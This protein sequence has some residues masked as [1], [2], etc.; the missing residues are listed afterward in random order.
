MSIVINSICTELNRYLPEPVEL[1]PGVVEPPLPAP[2]E[3]PAP[4]VV[5]PPLPVPG[6][7]IE[8][9]LSEPLGVPVPG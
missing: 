6:V 2:L 3:L 4:G 1:L 9:L 5:E 7:V 8:P